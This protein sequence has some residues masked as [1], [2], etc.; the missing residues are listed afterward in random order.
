MM[1]KEQDVIRP[2]IIIVILIALNGSSIL[3]A[4][5]KPVVATPQNAQ[6]S[7]STMSSGFEFQ[8]GSNAQLNGII[9]QVVIGTTQTGVEQITAGFLAG[10]QAETTQ[11]NTL[12]GI[13]VYSRAST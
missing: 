6:V 10:I 3:I 4:Q 7:W 11:A 2:I 13:I 1:T 12:S 9:G 8:S 5:K